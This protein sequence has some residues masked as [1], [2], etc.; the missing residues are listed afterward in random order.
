V[1]LLSHL[2][3]ANALT[4]V[5]LMASWARPERQ[6]AFIN[7][8]GFDVGLL[9]VGHHAPF[10]ADWCPNT[11]FHWFP[12]AVN[13]ELFQ[14]YHLPKEYDV[15]LYGCIE[16]HTYPLRARL[17]RLLARQP[18]L[19]LRHIPHPG[20]YPADGEGVIAGAKL[21]R[22][23]NKSWI[24]IA[25]SSIYKCVMAKYFEIAASYS[26]IAGDMPDE[27]KAIF[28]NDFIELKNEMADEEIMRNLRGHLASKDPLLALTDAAHRRVIGHHSTDAFADRLLNV[29][30]QI[31][32]KTNNRR[33]GFRSRP[34]HQ[35][36]AL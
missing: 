10:Y 34:F 13:T 9:A 21:A 22:E 4:V 27:G 17:A 32:A 28:W 31:S 14:N 6:T 11:E 33:L 26:A 36:T 24:T 35:P 16:A 1:P 23:I 30:R 7:G 2:P 3:Q 18:N 29:L 19:R 20:Y 15:L 5:E 8:Q 12:N 25:T